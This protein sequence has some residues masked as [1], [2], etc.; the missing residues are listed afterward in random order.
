MLN[1][2]IEIRTYTDKIK[3]I[4]EAYMW[5][6]WDRL[7]ILST[8]ISFAYRSYVEI[9]VVCAALCKLS[10][11]LIIFK[12]VFSQYK[13]YSTM[14]QCHF[15]SKN[16]IHWIQILLMLN[17]HFLIKKRLNCWIVSLHYI[18]QNNQTKYISTSFI[19]KAF[20]RENSDETKE[21]QRPNWY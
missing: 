10:N 14:V 3:F 2:N 4:N 15:Y 7:E 6:F 16:I 20:H 13:K 11:R 12:S 21:T 19:I 9:Y 17:K 1:I 18:S 8:F 5:K